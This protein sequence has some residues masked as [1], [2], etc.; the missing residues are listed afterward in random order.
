MRVYNTVRAMG[1][2]VPQDVSIIGYDNF[3]N[4]AE[5]L[6]P[7]LTTVALPYYQM[8]QQSVDTIHRLIGGGPVDIRVSKIRCP[9]V[10]RE[11]CRT[12]PA[13]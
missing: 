12:W 6:D 5:N 2:R 13:A 7:P 4:I 11:S 9:L 1:L 3:V 10:E 8:G